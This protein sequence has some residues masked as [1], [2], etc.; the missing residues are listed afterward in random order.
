MHPLTPREFI[1]SAVVG[2]LATAFSA[3]AAVCQG[4]YHQGF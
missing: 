3:H 2:S 4:R 1:K